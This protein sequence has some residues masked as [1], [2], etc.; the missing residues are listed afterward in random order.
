LSAANRSPRVA[1]S[2]GV[3][4]GFEAPKS[5]PVGAGIRELP[6]PKQARGSRRARI[7]PRQGPWLA[8]RGTAHT[9]IS[10][11]PGPPEY[12]C[13][14]Q[15][16]AAT[17][18][19]QVSKTACLLLWQILLLSLVSLVSLERGPCRQGS[20]SHNYCHPRPSA[21]LSPGRTLFNFTDIHLR[22]PFPCLIRLAI[23]NQQ[24]AE[25]KSP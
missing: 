9:R 6:R 24:Q 1:P 25:E 14:D 20:Q 4:L 23:N 21:I 19:Q 3:G 8:S 22:F 15:G 16:R 7:G 17:R 12:R 5:E 13:L 10:D 18:Q 2:A 11:Q